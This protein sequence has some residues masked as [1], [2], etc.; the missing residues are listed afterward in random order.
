MRDERRVVAVDAGGEALDQLDVALAQQ[1]RRRSARLEQRARVRHRRHS[2]MTD[3]L[4][5]VEAVNVGVGLFADALR[6]QGAPVIEVDWRPP[7]GG[8]DGLRV[9]LTELWGARGDRVQAANAEFVERLEAAAPQA[10]TVAPAGTVVPGLH[11]GLLLHSGPPIEW[12]RVCDP[13]RRALAAAVLF[14]GWADDR[15]GAARLLERGEIALEP[16]NDHG[17]VGPMTG[18]CS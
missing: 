7:A 8:D 2:T 9:A 13:Q 17:H 5:R 12:E 18:V 14:E 3:A 10:V 1:P 4:S 6:D 16:G 11:D 15:E